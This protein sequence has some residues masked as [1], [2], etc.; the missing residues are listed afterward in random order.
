MKNRSLL[1]INA[2]WA[3]PSVLFIRSIEPLVSI[4][5]C[6][7]F[8]ER[9]GHFVADIA[10]QIIRNNS[11]PS[12]TIYLYYLGGI[13]NLQWERMARRSS[14]IVIGNWLKYIDRWNAIIPGGNKH[15]LKSSET[16]SRDMFGLYQ[17]SEVELPFLLTEIE[18]AEN[19][20]ESKG[21]KQGELFVCL[22]VRDSEFLEQ[23]F[24]SIDSNYHSYRDSEIK[25]YLLAAEWLAAQG[26]MVIRMGKVMKEKFQSKHPRIVDYSFDSKKTDLLDIWLFANCSGVISTGTGLDVLAAIYKKPQLFLNTVPLS[27]FWSFADC[28]WV[29]KNLVWKEDS[30]SLTLKEYLEYSFLRT[31][32]YIYSGIQLIDLT[33]NEILRATMEFF[34]RLCGTRLISKGED[35]L[36]EKCWQFFKSMPN[37]SKLHSWKHPDSRIGNSWLISKGEE[38][39][40]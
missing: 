7:I 27:Y 38:F 25:D 23:E 26:V 3:I 37:F 9:A 17:T 15:K 31:S 32:D 20:L 36:Q 4:R 13:S 39:F 8:S 18:E 40:N 28:L 34:E 2:T 19:W 6:K 35:D 29:P 11:K 10:E 12:K 5:I 1:L 14:L 21:W 24:S 16:N 33:E 22:L 30:R